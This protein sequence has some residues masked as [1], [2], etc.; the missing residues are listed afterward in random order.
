MNIKK[1]L[2]LTTIAG[3]GAGAGSIVTA[4]MMTKQCHE[5]M[6]ENK[7]VN[8][9]VNG[10]L[11]KINLDVIKAQ[12]AF[13]TYKEKIIFFDE[14]AKKMHEGA[15][16]AFRRLAE[17]GRNC[18]KEIKNV[19][20]GSIELMKR[21]LKRM[22]NEAEKEID[23]K[24]KSTVDEMSNALNQ[25]EA[26]IDILNNGIEEPDNNNGSDTT[27]KMIEQIETDNGKINKKKIHKK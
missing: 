22:L 13:E 19:S 4:L 6:E 2:I 20:N 24:K 9:E 11:E 1:G 17:E 12:S 23:S 10:K 3:I 14:E 16:E 27:I 7:K 25:M 8:E 5:M 15:I 26:M 18:D 21:E